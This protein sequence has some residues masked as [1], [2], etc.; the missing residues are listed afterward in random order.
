[1]LKHCEFVFQASEG[2]SRKYVLPVKHVADCLSVL[3]QKLTLF[4]RGRA[5]DFFHPVL[6]QCVNTCEHY[7]LLD[8][9]A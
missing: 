9:V 2:T 4:L 7:V 1:M 5:E 6:L 3:M 8:I